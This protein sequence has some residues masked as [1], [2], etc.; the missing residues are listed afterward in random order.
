MMVQYTSV[1]IA[2]ASLLYG[3]DPRI[4][5]RFVDYMKLLQTV[6]VSALLPHPPQK[7]IHGHHISCATYGFGKYMQ[8]T[9]VCKIITCK[10]EIFASVF[11][12]L[13]FC[14]LFLSPYCKNPFF[15][16]KKNHK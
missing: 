2:P 14:L 5:Y 12:S 1:L 8:Y 4:S 3:M 16:G 9:A 7:H 13:S 6:E 10:I 15:I 11:V